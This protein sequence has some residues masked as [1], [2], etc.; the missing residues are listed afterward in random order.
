M[1][2]QTLQLL[3]LDRLAKQAGS[4]LDPTFGEGSAWGAL[5]L[6]PLERKHRWVFF[7]RSCSSGFVE[8]EINWNPLIQRQT[9]MLHCPLALS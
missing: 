5:L 3:A 8:L 7:A 6:G 4:D 1:K 9:Q 2:D